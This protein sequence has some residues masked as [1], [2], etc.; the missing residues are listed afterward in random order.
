MVSDTFMKRLSSGEERKWGRHM[1]AGAMG[2]GLACRRD[3]QRKRQRLPRL[4]HH[5]WRRSTAE[6]KP[7]GHG[8][9]GRQ[10]RSWQ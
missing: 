4:N 6:V 3:Q 8:L 2:D 7:T 9:E 1:G 10:D 5:P